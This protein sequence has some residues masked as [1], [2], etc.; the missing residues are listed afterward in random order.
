MSR[1]LLLLSTQHKNGI[2]PLEIVPTLFPGKCEVISVS[3]KRK[4]IKYSILIPEKLYTIVDVGATYRPQEMNENNRTQVSMTKKYTDTIIVQ[5]N[6]WS[7]VYFTI[8]NPIRAM[9]SVFTIHQNFDQQIKREE[10]KMK[11]KVI[12]E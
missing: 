1:V 5:Q 6:N 7:G 2:A 3:H 11:K 10:V 8:I 4:Y 12:V 9:F